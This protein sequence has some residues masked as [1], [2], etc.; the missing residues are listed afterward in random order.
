MK[1]SFLGIL[2][3]GSIGESILGSPSIVETA[4]GGYYKN[5]HDPE[6]HIP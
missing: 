4:D 6:Y 1:G 5:L 3:T 2:G